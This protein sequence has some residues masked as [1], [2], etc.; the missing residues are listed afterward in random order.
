M[1]PAAKIRPTG[2]IVGRRRDRWRLGPAGTLDCALRAF[3]DVDLPVHLRKED[4][5]RLKPFAS[6]RDGAMATSVLDCESLERGW[7]SHK[8]EHVSVAAPLCLWADALTKVVA[9]SGDRD[10]PLWLVMARWPG[11]IDPGSSRCATFTSTWSAGSAS[12]CT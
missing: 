4:C 7:S 2:E 10:G 3:G 12:R 9:A 1:N 6:L 5:G 8:R 11:G